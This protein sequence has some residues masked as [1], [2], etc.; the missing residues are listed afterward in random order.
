L[1]DKKPDW[2]KL[3]EGKEEKLYTLIVLDKPSCYDSD[4]LFDY[5]LLQTHFEKILCLRKLNYKEEKPFGFLF[6][7]TTSANFEE[8]TRIMESDLTE[9]LYRKPE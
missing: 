2:Q 5:D 6:T 4:D 3:L 9:Y 8:L 7:E 1:N